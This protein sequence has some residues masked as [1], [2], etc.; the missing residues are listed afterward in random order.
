M[1]SGTS[2][3]DLS[4]VDSDKYWELVRR[5]LADIFSKNPNDAQPLEN[6]V[7]NSSPDEQVLFYH[8]EPLSTAAGIAGRVPTQ[9]DI[10]EYKRLRAVVYGLP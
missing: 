2:K 6:E 9:Q 7:R 5:T 1:Q 3:Y 4:K 10:D 8:S